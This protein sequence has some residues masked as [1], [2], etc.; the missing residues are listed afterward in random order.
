VILIDSA[1]V[2]KG[3]TTLKAD[4]IVYKIS[5]KLLF[6]FKN[7][8][9]IVDKDTLRGDSLFYNLNTKQGIS[10]NGRTHVEK[11]FLSGEKMYKVTDSILHIE[12]GRFTTCDL[13]PP[14]Y[15]FY[16]KEMK[17]IRGDMAIVRPLILYIH[18]LPV[19][20]VPFWFFPVLMIWR[21]FTSH[22]CRRVLT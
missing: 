20:Y 3:N 4:S 10:F 9:L 22:T 6:A 19:F 12:N 2:V 18:D 1:L 17:V 13:E 14:H 16:S 5:S 8:I 21:K 15:F 7:V 11:G